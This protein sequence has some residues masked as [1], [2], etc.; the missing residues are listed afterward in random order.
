MQPARL[1]SPITIYAKPQRW[2]LSGLSVHRAPV[3]QISGVGEALDSRG[4]VWGT[5]WGSL[6]L[7]TSE[8]PKNSKQNNV[9]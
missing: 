7:S 5:L 6:P 9:R 4:A 1:A 2:E 8:R 3:R